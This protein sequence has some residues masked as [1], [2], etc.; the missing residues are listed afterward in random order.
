VEVAKIESR[1]RMLQRQKRVR[2]LPN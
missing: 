1:G 2:R